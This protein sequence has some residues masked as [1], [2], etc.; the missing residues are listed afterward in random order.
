M[1][2]DPEVAEPEQRADV[3]ESPPQ[4]DVPIYFP[5]AI[6]RGWEP[7]RPLRD[8]SARGGGVRDR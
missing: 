3:Y 1:G 8:E 2:V 6:A 7:L 4:E 5:S